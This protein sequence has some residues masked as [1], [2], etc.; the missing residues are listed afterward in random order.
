MGNGEKEPDFGLSE[1]PWGQPQRERA[2][3]G[4]NQPRPSERTIDSNGND[5][6]SRSS[7]GALATV[8]KVIIPDVVE[9]EPE[10]TSYFQDET[11]I[12]D[13]RPLSEGEAWKVDMARRAQRGLAYF[14]E[15]SINSI[16]RTLASD[17]FGD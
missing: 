7:V 9:L 15:D 14:V 10:P 8:P 11:N 12:V 17:L 1:I 6:N 4:A 3:F 2:N 13:V 16:S 5:W